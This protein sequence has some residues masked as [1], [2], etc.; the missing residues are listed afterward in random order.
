M[1]SGWVFYP[2]AALALMSGALM[3]MQRNGVHAALMLVLNLMSLAVLFAQLEGTFLFVVQL[4]VYAGAIM[5]L[6]LF[7]IM[8]VGVERTEDLRE[9]LRSQTIAGGILAVAAAVGLIWVLRLGF[10]DIPF[11]SLAQANQSGNV[12]A[13][14]RL[15]FQHYAFPFEF[16]SVL[17]V[18]AAL[19]AMILGRSHTEEEEASEVA[20]HSRGMPA[21][22]D[23][24]GAARRPVTA[25]EA[26]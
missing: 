7:V 21:P 23:G 25:R 8:L 1:T 11:A 24:D 2:A 13:L 17:L 6:F 16:T 3:V 14:G 12:Q 20:M 4:I 15:L 26:R 18:I 10:R 19:A 5:V 9:T 22:D